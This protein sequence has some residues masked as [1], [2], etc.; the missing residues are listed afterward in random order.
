[1]KQPMFDTLF[2]VPSPPRWNDF[3][4]IEGT[5]AGQQHTVAMIPKILL[6]PEIIAA[7]ARLFEKAPETLRLLEQAV[8]LLGSATPNPKLLNEPQQFQWAE[9]F[10]KWFAEA[11]E[12][13][14]KISYKIDAP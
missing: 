3:F 7:N 4:L 12:L 9:A 5:Y 11:Q 14:G 2:R 1:M 8:T 13:T 6:P 10:G